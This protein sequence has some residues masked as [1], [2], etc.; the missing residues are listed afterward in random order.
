LINIWIILQLQFDDNFIDYI[1]VHVLL[2]LYSQK[3]I[4]TTVV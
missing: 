4:V 1:H 3:R 2:G